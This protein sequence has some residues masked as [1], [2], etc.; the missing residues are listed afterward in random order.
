MLRQRV[1]PPCNTLLLCLG[2]NNDTSVII[3]ANSS[4]VRNLV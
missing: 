1:G 4:S 3:S 2:R